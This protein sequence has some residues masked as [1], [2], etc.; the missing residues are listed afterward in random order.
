MKHLIQSLF[1]ILVYQVNSQSL[2]KCG[3]AS[4]SSSLT[5]VSQSSNCIDFLN[6]FVPTSSD[7]ILEVNINFWV[8]TPSTNTSTGAWTRPVNPTTQADAQACIDAA[9]ST[10]SNMPPPSVTVA[11]V[12]SITN[13]KIKLK[14]KSFNYVNNDTR[15]INIGA[16]AAGTFGYSWNDPNAIN[17][18]LGVN[19]TTFVIAVSSGTII[20]YNIIP[21]SIYAGG[22]GTPA[23]S[24]ENYIVF[25]PQFDP[26]NNSYWDNISGYGK[27][28]AHEVGHVLG[29][30]HTTDVPGYNARSYILP[31]IGCCNRIEAEDY[32]KDTG[33][34]DLC[35]GVTYTYIAA[36]Q[37][38][39]TTVVGIAGSNNIMSQNTACGYN[40]LSP[41]QIALMQYNLRSIVSNYLTHS[42]YT[43]ATTVNQSFNYTLTTDQVWNDKIRY[44]KGDIIIPSG[45]TLSITCG[46]VM[47]N[48]AK[49]IVK[50][51]G[52]LV[53]N[54]GTI[55][56]IFGS[57]WEGI[58]AEGSPTL[59]Q[60]TSHSSNNGALLHQAMVKIING[61]T[62]SHAVMGFRNHNLSPFTD[63]GGVI[64]AQDAN[65]IN[66]IVDVAFMSYQQCCT[67]ALPSASRFYKCNFM[68][69]G[70]IG[71]VNAIPMH[72]KLETSKGVQF[73]GCNFETTTAGI[74]NSV[75]IYG[76]NSSFYVSSFG[77][78]T[79]T[80]FKNLY[81]GIFCN[82]N[83]LNVPTITKCYFENNFDAG[84]YFNSI[85]YLAFQTNT[86]IVPSYGGNVSGVYL[87]NCKYYKIKENV[88][89]ENPNNNYKTSPGLCINNSQTG[90][91]EVYKN[92]FSNLMM[93]INAMGNNSGLTN[94]NQ[95]D[96]LKINCNNFTVT[97]NKYDVALNLGGSNIAPSV[98]RKQGDVT[99]AANPTTVVRN[100]YATACT[101]GQNK[102]YVNP[103]STKIVDHGSNNQAV[104]QP[105]CSS[106]LVNVVP[107]SFPLNYTLHCPGNP[108]SSGGSSTIH[109]QKLVDMNN[110]ITALKSDN[111]DGINHFEIQSTVAGKLNLFLT[112]TLEGGLDSAIVIL[113]NNQGNMDDADVQLVFAYI[114]KND[115]TTA[116]NKVDELILNSNPMGTFLNNLL[117][118]MQSTNN[119]I[120]S[121]NTDEYYRN[122]F[123][124]YGSNYNL[125]GHGIA[126]AIL[127][128]ACDI[129]YSEPH[130]YPEGESA[131]RAANNKST[132]PNLSIT[133]ILDDSQ[134]SIY[135]NPTNADLQLLYKT[136]SNEFNLIEI[137]DVLGRIV[138]SQTLAINS[139]QHYLT[140]N[141]IKSGIYFINIIRNSN[142]IYKT[143]IIKTD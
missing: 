125:Q 81:K 111:P 3:N 96:G 70:L 46:V 25:T 60:Y 113:Q 128:A 54:G 15:Y 59:S 19:A 132:E 104:T 71:Q 114:A 76:H 44:F 6:Q 133:E 27:T 58:R 52:L 87:N 23:I 39:V 48:K 88:F 67:A 49:I 11:N 65:F 36:G 61:G 10:F 79:P 17:V 115:F 110:Y 99:S 30:D 97:S 66:N 82:G 55:T 101:N 134:I 26:N 136:K 22:G 89:I 80:K 91:H 8:Y 121:L 123:I 86:I 109:S 85:N 116:K 140:I 47:T 124:D 117:T 108:I 1:L 135:P 126:L 77:G 35:P 138:F 62:I 78:N 12:T 33:V 9:N 118:V 112:D 5:T 50:K 120:Y 94:P 14:L 45:K 37:T 95:T 2:P 38:S 21:S 64:I 34:W 143:K 119:G 129:D 56:N 42:S 72:V 92:T 68:T 75:G 139:S 57:T 53:V 28:L 83:P 29:L 142:L 69:T 16:V 4:N 7:P 84:A 31:P 43:A 24:P 90:A 106:S 20:G 130:N 63:A 18:L 131:S 137:R 74:I 105:T 13:A 102:W 141:G 103:F 122:Y 73:Y 32:F 98:A 51:G 40:Y 41:Q 93:G 127:K 100:M 107:A